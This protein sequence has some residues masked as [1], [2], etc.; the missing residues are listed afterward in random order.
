MSTSLHP[1]YLV[2]RAAIAGA[3]VLV[4]SACATPAPVVKRAAPAAPRAPV[5][6]PSVLLANM[7]K[8]M[9]VPADQVSYFDQA[10]KPMTPAAF[11][12]AI[13]GSKLRYS[14]KA[15]RNFSDG[16]WAGAAEVHLLDAPAVAQ[17]TP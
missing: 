11:S 16:A 15:S 13:N 14:V 12:T 17:T 9:Q 4:A 2:A 7:I 1:I 5:P 6:M 10:G 3:L 8:S